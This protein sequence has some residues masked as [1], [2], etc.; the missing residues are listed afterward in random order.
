MQ[1]ET[2]TFA[3]KTFVECKTTDNLL[4]LQ[5]KCIAKND[6]AVVCQ[7]A[8]KYGGCN[9]Y[10]LIAF[11]DNRITRQQCFG[12]NI[13]IWGCFA[14]CRI[15]LQEYVMDNILLY[16]S[17]LVF[18]DNDFISYRRGSDC[19]I[20]NKTRTA[21]WFLCNTTIIQKITTLTELTISADVGNGF[22]YILQQSVPFTNVK[23]SKNKTIN[24]PLNFMI[25]YANIH[26]TYSNN[27]A[28]YVWLLKKQLKFPK[29]LM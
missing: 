29:N 10:I 14:I 21:V 22:I 13:R 4:V 16:T 7:N 5:T 12:N 3:S 20:Y 6:L 27:I 17:E 15:D 24:I 25:K 1:I 26:L 19:Y 8:V 2:F 18:V 11:I 23:K 28:F 9:N